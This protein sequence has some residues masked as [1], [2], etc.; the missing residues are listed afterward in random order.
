MMII[1]AYC[2]CGISKYQ[3]IENVKQ[4]MQQIGVK[5]AVLAQ[6]LGEFDNSYISSVVQADPEMFAGVALVNPE[7]SCV[8]DDLNEIAAAGICKGVRWP[9]PVGFRYGDAIEH[10]AALGLNIVAY[11]PDGLDQ[12]IR[13]IERI[14]QQSPDATVVLSHMGDPGVDHVLN[15]YEAADVFSLASFPNVF[16]QLSGMKMFCGYPH[17][18][19]YDLIGAFYDAFGEDHLVW[20]SNFPVVGDLA[21][22]DRDL[23]LLLDNLL[24]IPAEAI[25]KIAGLNALKLWW[26]V[27]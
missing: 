7:S 13:E 4:V 8:L 14:L 22:Y 18:E 3:P 17:E 19:L 10:T 25:E 2:H 27:D 15:R 5:R 12:S 23:L 21:D 20:G 16:V 6:H 1:D 9:I 24:P 26:N 11:F